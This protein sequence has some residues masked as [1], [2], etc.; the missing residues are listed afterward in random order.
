METTEMNK[1]EKNVLIGQLV[2][3]LFVMILFFAWPIYFLS[4]IGFRL[5]L[6]RTV[7][8]DTPAVVVY[9]FVAP[10]VS[11]LWIP[12]AWKVF[13]DIKLNTVVEGV[14]IIHKS[15]RA[16]SSGFDRY[17]VLD[18]FGK[19]KIRIQYK[20]RSALNPL[21]KIKYRIAPSSRLLT[22]FEVITSEKQ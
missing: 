4:I 6:I 21:L 3:N 14:G 9:T 17:I 5:D 2:G 8:I 10:L 11:I 20:D 19:E 1:T 22:Q 18:A 15:G 16:F 7:A 12:K 13:R